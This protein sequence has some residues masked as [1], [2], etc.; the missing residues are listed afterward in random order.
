MAKISFL[1]YEKATFL[2][3]KTIK[4]CPMAENKQKNLNKLEF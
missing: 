2:K 3:G 1:F 4:L